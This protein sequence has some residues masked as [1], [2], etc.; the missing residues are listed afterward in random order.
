MLSNNQLTDGFISFTALV[1]THPEGTQP[2]SYER[3]IQAE[4]FE[5]V[6]G[7]FLVVDRAE[8]QTLKVTFEAQKLNN[9]QRQRNK[10]ERDAA[11]LL[12]ENSISVTRDV[13]RDVQGDARKGKDR[14]GQEEPRQANPEPK[15]NESDSWEVTPIPNGYIDEEEIF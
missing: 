10:R 8:T 14:K 12:G 1:L 4:L 11:K 15:S 2:R 7:G 13:T 9:R 5:E 3:L 6:E